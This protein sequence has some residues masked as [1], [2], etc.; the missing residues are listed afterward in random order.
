MPITRTVYYTQNV[1]QNLVFGASYIN[2]TPS[3]NIR[4]SFNFADTLSDLKMGQLEFPV[5]AG[6]TVTKGMITADETTSGVTFIEGP[7]ASINTALAGAQFRSNFF[8]AD[9]LDQEWLSQNPAVPTDHKGELCVQINPGIAHGLAVGDFVC[10]STATANSTAT[11][12]WLITAIDAANSPTRFWL[13]YRGGWDTD[14]R[15]FSSSYKNVSIGAYLQTTARVNI[16]PI[17][18]ISYCNPHGTF[19]VPV[20]ITNAD[21][22]A[23]E[24]SGTITFAGVFF[25]A[26]PYFSTAPPSGISVPTPN[27]WNFTDM[28]RIAQADNNYQAVQ[29]LFKYLEND[30][31]YLGVQA[32]TQLPGYPSGGTLAQKNVFVG[33]AI[34]AKA[35]LDTPTYVPDDRYGVMGSVQVDERIST[36]HATGVVRWNFFGTPTACSEALKRCTYYRPQNNYITCDFNVETRIVNERTRIYSSRGKE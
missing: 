6:V 30:P 26:E 17:V 16:A 27:T 13:A 31:L 32:Y 11:G 28:G 20:A 1:P 19:T 15:Y 23:V 14:D 35:R 24:E 8:E 3:R 34:E 36:Q 12:R 10:I 9:V 33:A 25:I 2:T 18:D 4:V 21:T 29:L 5:V 7:V 22:S